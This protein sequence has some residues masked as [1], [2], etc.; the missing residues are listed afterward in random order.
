MGEGREMKKVTEIKIWDNMQE[1]KKCLSETCNVPTTH[2]LNIHTEAFL[3]YGKSLPPPPPLFLT[4]KKK[5]PKIFAD[6]EALI[7]LHFFPPKSD[8]CPRGRDWRLLQKK[9]D[10]GTWRGDHPWND[11]FD[12]SS[13][14]TALHRARELFDDPW[15]LTG[16]STRR[17][18]V[19]LW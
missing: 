12:D 5:K 19:L 15:L 3:K 16:T 9:I 4:V 11:R 18:I 14:E 13:S 10:Y 17:G 6:L 8:K 2:I 1:T 7:S